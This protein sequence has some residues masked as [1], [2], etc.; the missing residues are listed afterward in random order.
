MPRPSGFLSQKRR[1]YRFIVEQESAICDE[2]EAALGI[3]HQTASARF[4]DLQALNWIRK[5]GAVRRTRNNSDAAVYAPVPE[6]Q[7]LLHPRRVPSRMTCYFAFGVTDLG[8]RIVL[9]PYQT[10]EARAAVIRNIAFVQLH[11]F[12]QRHRI[13]SVEENGNH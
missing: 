3:P 13:L 10:P 11:L 1:I 2:V 9:G 7:H 5:T 6:S 12:V 8:E 4:C